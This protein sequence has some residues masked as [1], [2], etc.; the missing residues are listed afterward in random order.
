MRESH[1]KLTS[2]SLMSPPNNHT[3]TNTSKTAKSMGYIQDTS[4]PARRSHFNNIFFLNVASSASCHPQT[5]SFHSET[6]QLPQMMHSASGSLINSPKTNKTTPTI[7]AYNIKFKLFMQWDFFLLFSKWKGEN[8][9]PWNSK[10]EEMWR[11]TLNA[12]RRRVKISCQS[13]S[14]C[15]KYGL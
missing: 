15:R 7:S 8:C 1:Y 4:H 14:S 9:F 10:L 5:Q 11:K 2:D 6:H 12:I 13:M 3:R